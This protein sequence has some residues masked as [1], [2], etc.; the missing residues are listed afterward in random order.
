MAK[1]NAF[2]KVVTALMEKLEAL[3]P[4]C[5]VYDMHSYNWRRWPREVPT[6]NL[7]TENVDQKTFGTSGVS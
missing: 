1:H 4:K 6:W 3:H 5:V 2:Y 7:G